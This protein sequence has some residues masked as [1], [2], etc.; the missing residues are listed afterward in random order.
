[1]DKEY[2]KPV[3][4]RKLIKEIKS[5]WAHLKIQQL[6]QDLR[7]LNDSEGSQ[8]LTIK[9]INFSQRDKRLEHFNSL[10]KIPN[11][12]DHLN[13]IVIEIEDANN[14]LKNSA[15]TNCTEGTNQSNM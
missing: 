7:E 10:E 4:L 15:N 8:N 3:T 13:N 12:F 5:K 9:Q 6:G 14:W 2:L 11:K 1:M